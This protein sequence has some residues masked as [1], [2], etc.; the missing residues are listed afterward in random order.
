MIILLISLPVIV[1][2]A[3]LIFGLSGL[4]VFYRQRRTGYHGKSFIMY[5]F[6][7]MI[8]SAEKI[9]GEYRSLNEA[10][11]PVFKIKNDPRF[12]GI[13]KFL[14][15]T[16]L[17]E[18][19]QL[20]NV[21]LGDMALI[22]PRPLPIKEAKKL[23]TWMKAREL[24][25]PGIISPWILEGYHRQSFDEWMKSDLRYVNDKSFISDVLLSFRT[26]GFFFS[27]FWR[28]IFKSQA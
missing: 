10:S 22:G 1:V 12:T 20:F 24:V 7:T 17:D 6:R 14:S 16:G 23:K 15:H 3:L 19:P 2:V 26:V 5:K 11:G 28:E 21:F 9:K 18:L 25:K 27:L 8:A 4:P 13:G